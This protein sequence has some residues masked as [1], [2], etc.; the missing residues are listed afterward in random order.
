MKYFYNYHA[1]CRESEYRSILKGLIPAGVF[2]L[3]KYL[4]YRKWFP[5]AYVSGDS[6]VFPESGVG[7]GCILR[8]CVVGVNVQLGDF[9]TIG[10]GTEVSGGGDIVIGRY[11]SIGCDCYIRSDNHNTSFKTTY[12]LSQIRSGLSSEA[13]YPV[14]PISIGNDVWIGHRSII[15]A[16]AD[17]GD[18]CV[19][20]AGSVVVN[21]KYPP[22][23]ILAGVPARV[24]KDRFPEDVKQRLQHSAWWSEDADRIF[25]D[26]ADDLES[27]AS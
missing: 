26:M 10:A 23:S 2:R 12:P 20:A 6:V 14:K 21:K 16:G 8:R 15:L 18:G 3:V 27:P 24:V 22:Y 11:C 13:L 17:I 19:V 25:E 4:K 7:D 5:R 9:T 1:L